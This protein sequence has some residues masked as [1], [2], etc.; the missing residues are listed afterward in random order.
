M[1]EGHT[2]D[3]L[4]AP[5]ELGKYVLKVSYHIA[6]QILIENLDVQVRRYGNC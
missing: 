6:D 5:K 2:L 3:M 1:I 4:I